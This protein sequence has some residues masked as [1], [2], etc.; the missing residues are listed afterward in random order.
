MTVAACLSACLSATAHTC[1]RCWEHEPDQRPDFGAIVQKLQTQR[2][3]GHAT[4]PGGVGEAALAPAMAL[5]SV[6]C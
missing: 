1:H 4:L 6:Q 3:L 5:S 2:R